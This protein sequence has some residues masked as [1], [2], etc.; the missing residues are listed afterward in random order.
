MKTVATHTKEARQQRKKRSWT[1]TVHDKH[2]DNKTNQ[3][4]KAATTI[5]EDNKQD[6]HNTGVI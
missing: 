2:N 4:K 6:D 1:V 5:D 3:L